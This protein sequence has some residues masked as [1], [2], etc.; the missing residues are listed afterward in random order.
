VAQSANR[1]HEAQE[2]ITSRIAAR[3][4]LRAGNGNPLAGIDHVLRG[5]EADEEPPGNLLWVDDGRSRAE[6]GAKGSTIKPTDKIQMDFALTAQ[7]SAQTALS[8]QKLASLLSRKAAEEVMRLDDDSLD[9]RLGL[10]YVID[11]EYVEDDRQAPVGAENVY[12]HTTVIRVSF[13]SDR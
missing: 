8:G 4:D 11:M 2:E 7:V 10:G 1:R 6:A 13:K 12:G 5:D 9:L 3:L